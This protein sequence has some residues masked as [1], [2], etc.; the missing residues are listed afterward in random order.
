MV[1]FYVFLNKKELE[2]K[3]VLT[4]FLVLIVFLFYFSARKIL[5]GL[6]SENK[7]LI[8]NL[9]VYFYFP[10]IKCIS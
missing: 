7:I 10:I 4:V 1:F 3:H 9:V 5:I 8:K 2:T 6:R